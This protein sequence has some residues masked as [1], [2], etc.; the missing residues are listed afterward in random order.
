MVTTRFR[1]AFN[2]TGK[3][4]P[5]PE[6][7]R[8]NPTTGEKYLTPFFDF[9]VKYPK[10]DVILRAVAKQVERELKVSSVGSIA[11]IWIL[12]LPVIHIS[13]L[14]QRL[15][16]TVCLHTI[17]H[18]Y[19]L[20][21]GNATSQIWGRLSPW[22]RNRSADSRRIKSRLWTLGGRRGRRSTPVPSVISAAV[23]L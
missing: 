3:Q 7:S 20:A 16:R 2:V 13:V 10:D 17:S 22:P 23:R 8:T 18:L 19:P 6:I 21:Y 1:N 5:D 15:Y 12:G 14:S 4:W 9:D 11:H